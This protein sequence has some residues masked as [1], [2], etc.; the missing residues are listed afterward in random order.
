MAIVL[1]TSILIITVVYGLMN[2]AFLNVLGLP[3]RCSSEAV[4]VDMMRAVMGESGVILIGLLVS[5]SAL[6]R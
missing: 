3:G 5:L 1:I 2:M 6:T 4:G